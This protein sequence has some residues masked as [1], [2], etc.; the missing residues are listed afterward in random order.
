MTTSSGILSLRESLKYNAVLT[1]QKDR[2][3]VFIERYKIEDV[4]TGT[5]ASGF[6]SPLGLQL[7]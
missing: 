2:S 4:S 6:K 7:K 1:G 5:N 3:D